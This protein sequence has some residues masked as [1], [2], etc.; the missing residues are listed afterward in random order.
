MNIRG[1]RHFR[2]MLVG[3][4]VSLCA[5]EALGH[6]PRGTAHDFSVL[7]WS[8]GRLCTPCHSVQD[9]WN[10]DLSTQ[11]Y[12]LHDSPTL[13]APDYGQPSGVSAQCLG[14][15]DGTVPLDSFGGYSGSHYISPAA[16]L[17]PD[18]RGHHPVSFT[19]NSALAA[20]DGGLNDPATTPSGLGGTVAD[21]ML[22]G[23][24]LECTTCHDQHGISGL[25]YF[26]VKPAEGGALCLTCHNSGDHTELRAGFADHKPGLGNPIDNGCTQ[27]HGPNLD[28]G[29][30]TS[31]FTCH[32]QI[33]AGGGPPADHTEL[34]AGFADHQPGLG[35]PFDNGC[36]QCHGPNLDDGFATSCFTCHG[37]I[38]AGG[39]PPADHTELRAGFA[40]HKPGL[41]EP[42]ANGCTQCH[43]PNLDDGFATSCFTC[44]GV[45]WEAGNRPPV[46]DSGG[47]Y[48]GV[49]GEPVEF[50]C[51]NTYDPDGDAL[52]YTWDFGDGSAPSGPSQ[53]PATT[54]AYETSGSYLAVLSV[55]DGVNDPV[56]V[57]V[58]VEV[59]DDPPPSGDDTWEVMLPFLFDQFTMTL[60]DFDGILLLHIVETD[61]QASFGIGA[62][63]DG[64][65]FWM[66]ITGSLFLGSV[67]RTAGTA[68]G[69]VF[70]YQGGEGSVWFAERL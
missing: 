15:H 48:T 19:F 61:G 59:S 39:G 37:Q 9:G 57:D 45:L 70:G 2:A 41:G 66:D 29:F 18:L 17:G 8:R 1:F 27:C 65:I 21:D 60:Q 55:S 44:H 54:H 64:V 22:D 31:C 50:D 28:D 46:V 63:Y 26:L 36:T 24:R 40:D 42:F 25:S 35:Q 49:V 52:S 10:H 3:L 68:W 34:R 12:T 20:V 43:G 38:W 23:G 32:G 14:C 58:A 33:W 62:E 69:L 53:A 56:S 6:D 5:L 51:S 4:A 11:V 30:A 47:P 67:D 13:T 7:P 16:R